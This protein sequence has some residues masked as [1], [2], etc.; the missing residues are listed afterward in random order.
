MRRDPDWF[1]EL[2]LDGFRALACIDGH[3]CR[4]VSRNGHPLKCPQLAEELAHAVRHHQ[5]VLDGEIVCLDEAGVPQF[6][7]LFQ[8]AAAWPAFYV[9]DV[10]SVDGRDC[11]RPRRTSTSGY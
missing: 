11:P 4:L 7:R 9:F 8:R 10:L 3:H 6:N 2:K 5:A 1:F